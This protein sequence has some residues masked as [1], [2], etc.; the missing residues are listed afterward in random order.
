MLDPYEATNRWKKIVESVSRIQDPILQESFLA[1]YKERAIREWGFCPDKK[2]YTKKEEKIVL[3]PWQQEIH[4]K[5]KTA[6]EYGVWELDEKTQAEFKSR[7][8]D[9][10]VK[11][12]KFSDLPPELQNK[13]ILN[14]YLDAI[15]E[16]MQ[17]C[18]KKL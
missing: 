7:M 2:N 9:F 1:T 14:G 4:D 8:R 18:M 3:E 17:D 11:G 10:V 15:F 12:G 13:H 5:L 16:E 6:K